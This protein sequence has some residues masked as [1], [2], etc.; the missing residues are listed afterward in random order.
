M[1]RLKNVVQIK[2]V[3][4]QYIGQAKS[5]NY[6]KGLNFAY[7]DAQDI[8]EK[9]LNALIRGHNEECLKIM[10]FGLDIDRSYTPLLNLC[11]TMLIGLS[12]LLQNNDFDTYKHKYKNFKEGKNS[13]LTKTKDLNSK[14][15]DLEKK[16]EEIKQ[17]SEELKPNSF[18][19]TKLFI[20]YKMAVKKFE[21]VKKQ[22]ISEKDGYE[23]IVE[24]LQEEISMLDKL[25]ELEEVI[26][27]LKLIV[28][29]CTTPIRFEW[30]LTNAD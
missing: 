15:T 5:N 7:I 17:K 4:P 3:L 8:Y 16:L 21:P 27:I 11:R 18:I 1:S 26:Q 14:I 13:L 30:A 9:S 25:M 10:I 20:F 29:V 28:E 12:Q 23:S 2:K 22:Y 6:L 19:S 24:K